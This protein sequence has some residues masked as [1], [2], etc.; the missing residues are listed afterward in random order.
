LPILGRK[1]SDKITACV[2]LSK[3]VGCP[4]TNL[5]NMVDPQVKKVMEVEQ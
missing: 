1:I 2:C 4:E 3:N 5:R